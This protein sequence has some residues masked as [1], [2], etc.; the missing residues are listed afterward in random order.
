[1]NYSVELWDSYN[2]VENNLLFHLRGLK[3]FI[4]LLQELN[5]SLKTFSNNLKKIFDMNL[6]VTTNE[7]LSIGIENFQNFILIQHNYLEKYISN[8]IS[9]AID[10][11][12]SLQETILK[13][14]NNNYKETINAEKNYESYISQI[15]FTRDKFHS[16]AKQVENKLLELEIKKNKKENKNKI[17]EK[18]YS[19]DIINNDNDED[20]DEEKEEEE[21]KSLEE[22]AKN[23]TGFAKDSE[24]IYLSY[25]KYTNRLQEEFIEIK[26]RNLNEIQNLEF[27][28]GENIK[29]CLYKYYELQSNYYKNMNTENENNIKLLENIDI[30]NDI[31]IYIK[32][33]RTNDIPPFKFDY[34]P[35][36]STLDK[37]SNYLD[38]EHM[39]N[40]NLK[41]KEQIKKLFP[42][43]KDISLLRTKTDKEIQNLINNILDGQNENYIN[44][45][46]ENIKIVSNK[47]LRRIFLKYLNKIRNNTHIILNDLSYNLIGNLLKESLEYS[48]KEKDF[49]SIKLI[50][51]IATNLFK[52]NK[53]SN[54]PRIF[55][56]NYLLNNQIWREFNFWENLIKYDILE[57]IH[58][59]K[60]YSLFLD[61]NDI[62]KNIRIK[63]TIKA[64]ISSNIYNMI[65]FEVNISLINKIINYF[66]NFYNLPKN[67][68]DYLNEIINNCKTKKIIINNK[69]KL[70]SSFDSA[71]MNKKKNKNKISSNRNN[72][73]NNISSI[74]TNNSKKNSFALEKDF[75]IQKKGNFIEPVKQDE[76][77]INDCF[78]EIGKETNNNNIFNNNNFNNIIIMESKNN[79][80]NKKQSD[81]DKDKKEKEGK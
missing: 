54:K 60:K 17:K 75:E 46:E 18:Q 13:K 50:M 65:S 1:M 72:I 22:Q 9:Q 14:L 37:Q 80:I 40:I 66:S 64:Q 31:E 58:N 34:V 26:K 19:D 49:L 62:L 15:E 11:L 38:D 51:I 35:Y 28:L 29:N 24:K 55:L 7:S 27:E 5:K 57:E 74:T 77:Q 42:E 20:I 53:I 2:K 61:E 69:K 63:D 41:V 33:N 30:N 10:P 43:E 67:I 81:K 3:D 12:N 59:Q 36:I 25:I 47:N 45:N 39:K 4:Y 56:H 21:I 52:I 48:Y 8:L 71:L 76:Q 73:N 16:R 6:S 79:I 44:I 68:A 32:N 78:D 23:V 70:N